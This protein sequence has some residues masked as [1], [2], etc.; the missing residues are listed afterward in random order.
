MFGVKFSVTLG[1]T[2]VG[3]FV[4]KLSHPPLV[5]VLAHIGFTPI[6]ALKEQLPAVQTAYKDLGFPR[7]GQ[8]QIPSF[9][10]TTDKAPVVE[11]KWRWDFLD[12]ARA[13]GIVLTDQSLIVMTRSY[14]TFESFA[15]VIE[16][17]LGV[18]SQSAKGAAMDRVGLRY[19]DHIRPGPGERE[20]EFVSAEL[21][22]FTFRDVP[23]PQQTPRTFRVESVARSNL[24]TLAVRCY[25]LPPH[26]A[27]PQD[28]WPTSLQFPPEVAQGDVVALD[29]DHFTQPE[30]EFE[31]TVILRTV[32]DL[33]DT[34][35]CAFKSAVTPLAMARWNEASS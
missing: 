15:A 35:S 20:E 4:P 9:V 30:F 18:I 29:I 16:R 33:Q 11:M 2:F 25:R 21:L 12:R 14:T 32:A 26:Q 22:G 17:A 10:F 28:L 3:C 6:L 34:A 5:H 7:F 19:I 8:S 13:T 24:G 27:L 31:P 1:Y 23:L